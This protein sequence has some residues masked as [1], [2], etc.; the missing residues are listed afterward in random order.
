LKNA[1]A[2]AAQLQKAGIEADTVDEWRAGPL[3]LG[4]SAQQT[5]HPAAN[6]LASAKA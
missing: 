2:V 4:Q 1:R 5:F 6:S 3:G